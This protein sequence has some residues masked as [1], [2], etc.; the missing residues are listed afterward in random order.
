M[1]GD[2]KA[3]VALGRPSATLTAQRGMA[4]PPGT[5]KLG[6][7][8]DLPPDMDWPVRPAFRTGPKG[9]PL[10]IDVHPGDDRSY[11]ESP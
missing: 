2:L 1:T 9:D 4:P 3:L 11:L 10:A 5:S 6:G 7:L 8:P